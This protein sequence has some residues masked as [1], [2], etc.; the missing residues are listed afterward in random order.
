MLFILYKIIL[1]GMEL[2]TS[3]LLLNIYSNN[4]KSVD[5]SSV[6][7]FSNI[8]TSMSE[9]SIRICLGM[10]I[11]VNFENFAWYS[12]SMSM[13]LRHFMSEKHRQSEHLECSNC[14]HCSLYVCKAI[15]NISYHLQNSVEK[16]RFFNH[17]SPKFLKLKEYTCDET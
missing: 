2:L 12:T 6:K 13:C 11:K 15:H 7:H 5:I 10:M 16:K 8:E 3:F 9:C 14:F 1:T 17:V 4:C